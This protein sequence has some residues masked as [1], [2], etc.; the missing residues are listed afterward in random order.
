MVI[1][2]VDARGR[3]TLTYLESGGGMGTTDG[4]VY[5]LL[6]NG[7]TNLLADL[8]TYEDDHNPDQVNTYGLSGLSAECAAS[9]PEDL[10]EYPGQLDSNV[11]AVAILDDGSRVVADAGGND[12]VR[13]RR[14]AGSRPSPSCR[15]SRSRWTRTS[16]PWPRRTSVRTCPAPRVRR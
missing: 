7:R 4:F 13:V 12:L 1:T 15:R 8:G 10:Q 11:Y 3:G 16:S 5:R 14:T 6:P 2:G 9:V